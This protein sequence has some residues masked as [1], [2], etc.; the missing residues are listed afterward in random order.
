MHYIKGIDNYKSKKRSAVTL[1]K[2]DGFHKGHMKLV[3][4]VRM[5]SEEQDVTSIICS[6]DMRPLYERIHSDARLLMTGDERDKRL[7]N[8]V[9]YFI[10][11]PFT[12]EFSMMEAEDF[13]ENILAG[14]FHAAYVVVGEDF[15]FGHGK[16]G[17]IHML[18]EYAEKYDYQLIVFEKERYEG[19]IISSTH[20]K[21]ALAEGDMELAEKL[22]GYPYTFT[23]TVSH[24]KQIG[25]RIGVPTLNIV[26]D[27]WKMM[28]PNGVYFN[29]VQI[30]GIW[31]DA[32][33]NV[34]VKPTVT[35]NNQVVIES[36][37]FDY[38][39]DAYEKN[40]IVE[41]YKFRRPETKFDSIEDMKQTIV[42]DIEAGREYF[43]NKYLQ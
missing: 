41:L 20:V 16:R 7:E 38:A 31:Y 28:P 12:K 5:L 18:A 33:G 8:K 9:D 30:D 10:D 15:C 19:R 17:N 35:D 37:L 23:G 11:C 24:G 22:L 14:I 13:I 43:K 32:I 25:R 3:D 42:K 29:R 21:E 34:G 36:Y 1:G 2:F 6:F 27:K 40:I 26:P 4:Q 39:G